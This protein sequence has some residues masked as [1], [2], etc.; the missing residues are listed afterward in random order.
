MLLFVVFLVTKYA[1]NEITVL[2]QCNFYSSFVRATVFY[3]I[4]LIKK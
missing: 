3:N 4:I 1:E 2:N